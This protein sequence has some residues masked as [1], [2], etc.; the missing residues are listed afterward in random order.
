M[1]LA[2]IIKTF[3]GTCF[4]FF[5]KIF[6]QNPFSTS[7][8]EVFLSPK[9]WTRTRTDMKT[10]RP[11]PEWTRTFFFKG[12][13]RPENNQTLARM[14]PKPQRDL[15]PACTLMGPSLERTRLDS[16]DERVIFISQ[17]ALLVNE[18]VFVQYVGSVFYVKKC[19]LLA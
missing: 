13:P 10:I 5:L 3:G 18:W 17:F 19:I 2:I 11:V 8:V 12:G 9:S 7:M 6:F 16:S 4:T 1:L 14:V 15:D